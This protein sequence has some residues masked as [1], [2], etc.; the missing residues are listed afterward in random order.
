M[1]NAGIAAMGVNITA[2]WGII[3]VARNFISGDFTQGK[4]QA[5]EIPIEI[6]LKRVIVRSIAMSPFAAI[7]ILLSCNYTQTNFVT[8]FLLIIITLELLFVDNL[9]QIQVL[10][11]K[12]RTMG[13]IFCISLFF[14]FFLHIFVNFTNQ[15]ALA[16]W[17]VTLFFYLIF[18]LIRYSAIFRRNQEGALLICN[19]ISRK[20]ITW[21]SISNH[22]SFYLFNVFLFQMNPVLT[23]E[24]RLITAWVIN[25]ASTIYITLNNYYSIKFVNG[26]STRRE[27]RA[28]NAFAMSIL[29]VI[30]LIF[31]SVQSL[32]P[33]IDVVLD[34]WLIIGTCISSLSFFV[35]S[36]IAILY[37][38]TKTPVDFFIWRALTWAFTLIIQL[39]G[40]YI[41]GTL[42]F[43]LCSIL[44]CSYVFFLYERA[45]SA[46]SMLKID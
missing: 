16:F 6:T 45:L 32:I 37:L 27:Q 5:K 28:I 19:S 2:I 35:Y 8:T 23:G 42:G 13:C 30:G 33:F 18:S 31:F 43:I 22:L 36:R 24:I 41:Y 21:E 1:S 10:Y 40:V 20:W 26:E 9:R 17:F 12:F 25:S 39:F 4:F 34:F 15:K 7:F 38:Q 14:T 29:L 44:S 3:S 46:L 11:Q